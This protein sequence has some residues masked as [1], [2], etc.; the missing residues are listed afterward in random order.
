[1]TLPAS[2]PAL[3]TDATIVVAT[4]LVFAYS[5]LAGHMALVR[6]SISVYVGLVLANSFGKPIYEWASNG[7]GS[8]FPINQTTMNLILLFLPIVLL[9]FG[10]HRSHN[11]RHHSMIV[12][13]LLAAFTSM[14]IVSSVL[15]L[16]DPVTLAHTTDQSNLASWIY[17]LRL[18]WLAAVPLTIASSALVKHRHH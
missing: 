15:S 1:M 18:L 8:G 17:E 16:L 7:G 4:A 5:L 2:I 14:L 13:F 10:P 11:G 9:Q 3:S 12:T 6:E